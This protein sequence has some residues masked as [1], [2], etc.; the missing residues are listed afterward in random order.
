MLGHKYA[1]KLGHDIKKKKK[2]P[3]QNPFRK[4]TLLP[5]QANIIII[6]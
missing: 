5:S 4:C 2:K 1:L 6:K 3:L